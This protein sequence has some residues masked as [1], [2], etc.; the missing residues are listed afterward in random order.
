M[1]IN[2]ISSTDVVLKK[3]QGKWWVLDQELVICCRLDVGVMY[4]ILKKGFKTDLGSVPKIAQSW[5]DRANNNLLPFLLHDGG[6]TYGGF[7]RATWD[8]LLYQSL[9]L[10]GMGWFKA[11]CVHK[12]V[13]LFGDSN[14]NNAPPQQQLKVRVTWGHK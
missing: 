13:A 3:I 4:M 1:K 2:H 14:F 7:A 12:A 6:Y 9:R 10:K 8:K 5:I 11:Q